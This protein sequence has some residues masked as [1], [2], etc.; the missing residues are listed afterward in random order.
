MINL[1]FQ[2]IN[3]F[4]LWSKKTELMTITPPTRNK[5]VGTSPNIKKVRPIPK[6]GNKEY[7]GKICPTV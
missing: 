4:I 6:I 5:I 2:W 7:E 1:I 3:Y